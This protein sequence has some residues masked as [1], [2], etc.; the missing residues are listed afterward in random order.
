[1][2]RIVPCLLLLMPFVLPILPATAHADR[3]YFVQSYT[4]YIPP[5]GNL[6]LETITVAKSG[7]GDS[8]ATAWR[9]RFEF[10][11]SVTDRFLAAAYLNFVQDADPGAPMRFDGPSLEFIYQLAP[12]RKLPVDPAAYLEVRANGSEIELEPKLLLARRI[13]RLVA[14]ANVIGEFERHTAGEEEGETEK[15]LLVTAGFSRE[16][17]SVFAIGLE[18]VYER[19]FGEGDEH[20]SSWLLGPTVNFQTAKIQLALGWHPQISGSPATTRGLNLA[21]FPRSEFRMILGVDL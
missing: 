4:P 5:A 12:P 7:Q 3:R 13:Y 6:E 2:R 14:V 18:S 1:M 8:T 16:I 21:D 20:P 17:G 19:G 11:Y 9:N 15:N 10:E